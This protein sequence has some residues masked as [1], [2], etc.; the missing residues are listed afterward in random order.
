[1]TTQKKKKSIN[2]IIG[3]VLAEQCPERVDALTQIQTEAIVAAVFEAIMLEAK[4]GNHI[5]VPH[6]GVFK[7]RA[8]RDI[9]YNPNAGVRVENPKKGEFSL[10]FTQARRN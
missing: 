1:M 8:Q 5:R 2:E 6:F 9:I 7:G 3:K 10:S 4:K